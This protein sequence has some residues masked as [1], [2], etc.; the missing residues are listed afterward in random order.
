MGRF[1]SLLLHSLLFALLLAGCTKA[2]KEI[3]PVSGTV[4]LDGNPLAHASVTFQP[5]N[6]G[7]PS[8]GVTNDR[9]HYVLEYSLKELGAKI[10]PC[11]VK[12]TTL[13]RTDD[14]KLHSKEH[15]PKRYDTKP[16]EVE[17]KSKPNTIDIPLT[18]K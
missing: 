5:K 4:T 10:G 15:V 6:G 8:Y 2:N 3:S 12:V 11:T 17:V 13:S 16:I 1:F 7:R 9:G 18:T 14:G